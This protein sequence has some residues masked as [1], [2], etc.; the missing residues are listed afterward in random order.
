MKTNRLLRYDAGLRRAMLAEH[1]G[2]NRPPVVS[3][4]VLFNG[5]V[6]EFWSGRQNGFRGFLNSSLVGHPDA[7]HAVFLLLPVKSGGR[8]EGE[9]KGGR[10]W[11]GSFKGAG[12]NTILLSVER[13]AVKSPSTDLFRWNRD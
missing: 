11:A 9:L 3:S 10:V 7:S 4:E 12:R 6:K 1:L 5:T 2:A 13:I 8:F